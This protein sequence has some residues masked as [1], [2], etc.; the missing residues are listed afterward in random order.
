V[1][2]AK[3]NSAPT[4][5]DRWKATFVALFVVVMV[6]AVFVGA[7]V[8][9]LTSVGAASSG[10]L[11]A[12]VSFYGYVAIALGLP[13]VCLVRGGRAHASGKVRQRA[14]AKGLMLGA[15]PIALAFAFLAYEIGILSNG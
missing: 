2:E 3:T 1:T 12:A 13:I 7:L 10:D 11:W 9:V 6:V 5:L 8:L 14:W 4:T 15:V